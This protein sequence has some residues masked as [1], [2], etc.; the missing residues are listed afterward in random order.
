MAAVHDPAGKALWKRWHAVYAKR[1]WNCSSVDWPEGDWITMSNRRKQKTGQARTAKGITP[2]P[3]NSSNDIRREAR[4]DNAQSTPEVARSRFLESKPALVI[5]NSLEAFH[6]DLPQLLREHPA[7]GLRITGIE[8]SASLR[9]KSIFTN[10]VWAK[11]SRRA[12]SWSNASSAN[13]T[14]SIRRNSRASDRADSK[15]NSWRRSLKS[16]LSIGTAYE[17]TIA[18]AVRRPSTA[19]LMMP[20]AYPAPSPQG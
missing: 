17:P 12:S 14:S 13:R 9:L 7:N 1:W 5:R 18:R 15:R 2:T 11:V 8:P 19:A 3:E 6:R 20:P 10:D 4:A 16:Y